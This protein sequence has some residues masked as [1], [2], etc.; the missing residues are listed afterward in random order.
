MITFNQAENL[1]RF[2]SHNQ[3]PEIHTELERI[4]L[5]N[6]MSLMGPDQQHRMIHLMAANKPAEVLK[7]LSNYPSS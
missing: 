4:G 7:H 1:F 6:L 5:K 2:A 3:F